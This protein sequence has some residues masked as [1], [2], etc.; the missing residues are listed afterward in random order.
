MIGKILASL[1]DN[2]LS[3]NTLVV[4]ASDNGADWHESDIDKYPH[5]ANAEWRGRKA[6]IWEAGHRVP[7]IA[8]WPGHIPSGTVSQ[9]IAS[10]TDFMATAA[11]ILNIP[12]PDDAAEDSFDLFPA[13]Q[14]R[15][16]KPIRATIIDHS[17][18]GMFTIR[19]GNW[20]LELG[21][22]SGGFSEP[23]HVDPDPSGVQGQL[24]DLSIDPGET[25]NVWAKHPDIVNRLTELLKQ[26]QEA[27]RTR[28]ARG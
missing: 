12:L 15:N 8:R 9:E 13:L 2:G 7:C 5:R 10:L 6:D 27:G 19:E 14:Q 28:P 24:Y 18:D 22:G 20:K 11:A 4:F 25:N 16:T 23:R 21:L 26:Y 1:D 17:N 3:D